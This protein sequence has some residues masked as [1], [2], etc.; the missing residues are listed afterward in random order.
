MTA[1]SKVVPNRRQECTS[2]RTSTP[3][4]RQHLIIGFATLY[5]IYFF[6]LIPLSSFAPHS[7]HNAELLSQS[8]VALASKLAIEFECPS[9][10]TMMVGKSQ[11]DNPDAFRYYLD[12]VRNNSG[13][14]LQAQ[15]DSVYD[16]WFITQ[17]DMT[18]ILKPWKTEIFV[19]NVQSGDSI[20]ES[21]CGTGINLLLTSQLLSEH[22]ISNLKVYGN[23]YLD[24][25]VDAANRIWDGPEIASL[26]NH[27]RKI[28]IC[29][30]DSAN[31]TAI[32][33]NSFDLVYTG[34]LDVLSDP[35]HLAPKGST[36]PE[37]ILYHVSKCD[38]M[39]HRTKE[40][41][42]QEA[43]FAAWVGEMIRLVKPGKVV[44]IES[45]AQSQCT[46]KLDQGGVDRTWWN[47]AI[48]EYQWDVDP[49]SL[50]LRDAD[51]S[52][53]FA[54]VDRYHVMMRKNG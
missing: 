21:A 54:N 18:R 19:P 48:E 26:T 13:K 40:Q 4:R 42:M 3:K 35:L 39:E 36:R 22:G 50:L 8:L 30:G 34:Y 16:S 17:E 38:D 24:A 46:Q 33:S 9:S 51:F 44:A 43:W 47:R 6:A 53:S 11:N 10:A 2:R 52:S 1:V 31:L 28:A 7:K 14:N 32:P 23:D 15:R 20:Y 41:H 27:A 29:Q 5:C 25:S 45:T 12:D 37:Q 49:N